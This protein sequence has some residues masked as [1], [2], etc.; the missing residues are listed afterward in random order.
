M[1]RI[2]CEALQLCNLYR[3]LVVPMH[4]A[5]ALT[6]HIDRTGARATGPQNIS[7][8]D[9]LGRAFQI[10]ARNL[11]DKPRDINMRRARS[12]AGS[13][14]AVQASIRLHNGR[15]MTERRMQVR[16]TSGYLRILRSLCKKIEGFTHRRLA[17]SLSA[18][19]NQIEQ[20]RSV[21]SPDYAT[22]SQ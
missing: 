17:I 22:G 16:K 13:I 19:R 21:R 9:R 5:C 8:E 6:Q 18:F 11:L 2:H 12:R 20:I 4:H 10:S 1:Q 3:L 15:T 14:E 7:V